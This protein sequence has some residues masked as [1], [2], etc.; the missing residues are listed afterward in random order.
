MPSLRRWLSTSRGV[1][2]RTLEEQRGLEDERQS[3]F[4]DSL[5]ELMEHTGRFDYLDYSKD[6]RSKGGEGAE[7]TGTKS[8]EPRAKQFSWSR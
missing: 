8:K 1:D 7:A 3:A 6:V 4:C 2:N 5:L